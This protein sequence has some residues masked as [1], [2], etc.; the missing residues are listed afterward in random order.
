MELNKEAA[1]IPKEDFDS[2]CPFCKSRIVYLLG[3]QRAN[4][5]GS[6]WDPDNPEAEVEEWRCAACIKTFILF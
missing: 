3:E 5:H 2:H 4:S 1:R 6:S